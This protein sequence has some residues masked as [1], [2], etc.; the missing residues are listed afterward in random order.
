MFSC[1]TV[2]PCLLCLFS[3]H[4]CETSFAVLAH[5]II[6]NEGFFTIIVGHPSLWSEAQVQLV[7]QGVAHST[8]TK[9]ESDLLHHGPKAGQAMGD[10]RAGSLAVVN[11]FCAAAGAWAV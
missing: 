1:S 5:V 4:G 3:R 10:F 8:H 11:R 7:A 2:L 6:L 9:I